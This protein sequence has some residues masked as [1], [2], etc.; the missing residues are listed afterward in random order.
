[1]RRQWLERAFE[2]AQID[3]SH[4]D[5]ARGVDVN[6]RTIE[7]VYDYYGRLFLNNAQLEWAGMASLIG[8]S[9]YAGF[10]DIGFLPDQTR[11]LVG[12]AR[13]R[14]MA[15]GGRLFLHDAS[16]E[17]VVG[18]LGFFEATLLMM[19]RKIFEDQAPMHEA[20]LRAGLDAIR[21]LG[22]A[23]I[24]DEATVRAWEQIDGG[25]PGGVSGGN[26]TLLYREQHDIIDRFY[27]DMRGHAPPSGRVFT[28][29][30]T[31]AGTPAIP[32]AQSYCEVFPLTLTETLSGW[33]RVALRTPLPAGNLALFANRWKLIEENTLPVY[34]RLIAEKVSEVRAL[35]ECPI[36]QRAGRFRLLRRGARLVLALATHWS[37]ILE[38]VPAAPV[39]ASED[40]TIDLTR[41]PTRADAGL[42]EASD[43][44]IWTNPPSQPFRVS[45]LLPGGRTF[46]TE[47]VL[48]ALVCSD[49]GG[50]PSRLTVKFP[51]SDLDGA[52]RTLADLATQWQLDE[53]EIAAWAARAATVTSASHTYSTRVFGAHSAGFVQREVQVAHHIEQ[54]AYVVAPLFSWDATDQSSTAAPHQDA[55]EALR[56]QTIPTASPTDR[57]RSAG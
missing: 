56:V 53:A 33:R 42:A 45:L 8:P 48:V 19:Q 47:A 21:E 50:N 16:I 13:H 18:N 7:R 9:F 28:Y 49:L 2:S 11:R 36:G 5:P 57:R 31:L 22:T 3:P 30:L 35:L 51:A 52:R 39:V 38:A 23:G 24:I 15:R 26:R 1:L 27:A 17:D 29:L 55:H 37:L 43:S 25:E 10:E 32:G 34:R 44:R 20:Y 14:L 6:R 12:E 46:S 54:D 41:R 4:W 40:V